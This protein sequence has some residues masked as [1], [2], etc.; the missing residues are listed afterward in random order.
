MARMLRKKKS[1]K[2]KLSIFYFP[3]PSF[4]PEGARCAFTVLLMSVYW[5][6][7]LLPLPVTALLPVILFPMLGV[8]STGQVTVCY[9]KEVNMLMVG[10]LI[11]AIAIEEVRLHRRIAI[12]IMLTVG[13]YVRI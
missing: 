5:L 10:G 2:L 3:V 12:K 13:K 8:L 11:V 4:S 1:Q 6:A 9:F 7:E